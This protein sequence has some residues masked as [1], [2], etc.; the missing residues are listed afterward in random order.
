M[1]NPQN[2]AMANRTPPKE[3]RKMPSGH[4]LQET[5]TLQKDLSTADGGISSSSGIY[6]Y[7][8]GAIA[9]GVTGLVWSDFATNWQRVTANV[10]LRLPLAWL[11]ALCELAAG[12]ALLWPRTARAAAAILTLLFA[13]FVLLWVPPILHA[14]AIYDSWGNFFEETSLVI[15]GLVLFA[16]LAPVGSAW[17][18]RRTIISR[19]YGICPISFGL[20]HIIYLKG[21]ATWVPTWIPPGQMFWAI[22]T[23]V[24]FLLAAAAILS[25]IL[26]GLAARLLTAMIVGFELL[27]WIPKLLAAPHDHFAWAGNAISITMAG[28]A[29]IVADSLNRSPS[30]P[31]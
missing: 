24:C 27:I 3:T 11:T 26:A 31:T 21:V 5:S 29:W 1:P 12:A 25:G 18:A 30:Q 14:P 17:A 13:V 16:S 23:T 6:L 22:A 15:A 7:A 2:L 4:L 19:L 28:A 8:M 10:P 9:L 20:D